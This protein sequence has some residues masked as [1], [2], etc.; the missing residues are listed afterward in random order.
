[1]PLPQ[2]GLTKDE[3]VAELARKRSRDARWQDGRTF[4]MVYDGGSSVHEVAEAAATMF[5]HE[6]AL[7]TRAFPSLAEIQ[8]EVVGALADLFHGES[9]SGFMTSGGT[10][11]IIMAVTAA[12]ERGRNEREITQ[13]EMVLA[14]SAHAAFHKAAHYL[15]VRVHKVG[16]R[17]DWR[18]DVDAMA[19]HVNDN[20][21]LVVGSAPQ[22]PQGVIDPIPELAA[23]AT[24]VGASM[25]V[26]ACM[27]GLVLPFMEM[28]GESV[29][30]WD[31]RVDGVTT[32]SADL[33]K[34]G[35]T[36]KGASVI[37]HR[38][39]E[40]RRYQTFVFDD[41]LG[42]FYASPGMQGSRAGLPMAAAWAVLH[43]LGVDG[44]RQLV[45]IAI[46]ATRTLIAGIGALPELAVLG[47]PE[48]HI[49]AIAAAAG[50][51]DVDVFSVGD[52]LHVGGW[53]VDRQGPPANLHLTVSAGNA[54]VIDEFV[55][56]LG[57]AV[58]QVAGTRVED[59]STNYATLE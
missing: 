36:P 21:V 10:E 57:E 4:G 24:S 18:T 8:S 9:A 37:L 5:L 33:H 11:S 42:G 20:T 53:H 54:A 32:I 1:M 26:D 49:V 23:L 45:Q 19:R 56:D 14:E 44:Y 12:R 43:H 55:A 58:A 30:P 13:P 29:A 25:H 16:V 7:N 59:R 48:A 47:E 28:N 3:V 6:N 2:H 39:K 35:Y 46:D 41:W 31:F 38:S 27:G 40:L 34:L 17:D 15:G 51:G 50:R 22:Y 52:A